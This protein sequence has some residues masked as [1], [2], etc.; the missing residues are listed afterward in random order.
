VERLPSLR[1]S[2]ADRDQAAAQLR[3]ATVEGRITGQELEERLESLFASRTYGELD[4]LLAD[5]PVN[6]SDDS[7]RVRSGRSGGAVAAATL[8]LTTLGMLALVGGHSA[9]VVV[10][11]RVREWRNAGPTFTDAHQAMAVAASMVGVFAVLVVC[12]GIAW[13]ATRRSGSSDV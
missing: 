8:V 6:R 11:P 13:V 10:G 9:V 2:D 12:A 1:A 5:L 7:P 3:E 4:A